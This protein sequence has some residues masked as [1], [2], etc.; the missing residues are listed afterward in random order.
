MTAATHAPLHIG[1]GFQSQAL[2]CLFPLSLGTEFLVLNPHCSLVDP[3][4]QPSFKMTPQLLWLPFSVP[5][6]LGNLQDTVVDPCWLPLHPAVPRLCLEALL[7]VCH[8]K[9]QAFIIT[10]APDAQLIFTEHFL[11]PGSALSSSPTITCLIFATVGL[12]VFIILF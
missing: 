7:I 4:C 8:A 3:S 1:G 11:A 10:T 5:S 12:S 2:P 9:T 6:L